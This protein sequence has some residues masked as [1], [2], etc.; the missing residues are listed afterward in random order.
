MN[1]LQKYL[2]NIIDLRATKL[3]ISKPCSKDEEF[4][5]IVIDQKSTTFQVAKYTDK[6][7]FH[8]NIEKDVLAR[9]CFELINN[10]FQQVNA[11]SADYEHMIMISK[12]GA[13]TYKK[14]LLRNEEI[15]VENESHNRKKNYLI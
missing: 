5:K 3:I 7:V 9:R 10:H 8:E 13:C 15:R 4:K 11:F 6:H 12:R 2:E 1:E 14:R